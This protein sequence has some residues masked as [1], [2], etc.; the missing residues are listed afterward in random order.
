MAKS[1][2][3]K[4]GYRCASRASLNILS[5]SSQYYGLCIQ[6]SNEYARHWNIGIKR[7]NQ[8][9]RFIPTQRGRDKKLKLE[10]P[11]LRKKII[12]EVLPEFAERVR[13]KISP[14]MKSEERTIKWYEAA[15]A[16]ENLSE[17]I[18]D[19][20]KEAFTYYKELKLTAETLSTRN[21]KSGL[22]RDEFHLKVVRLWTDLWSH[23]AN[24]L[25][26]TSQ[27]LGT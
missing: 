13:K 26:E 8:E 14:R 16:D 12:E 5:D 6:A 19:D 7:I 10:I 4:Y 18:K 27:A 15:L 3:K 23:S 11:K 1:F 17:E 22:T 2:E 9:I 21:T 20:L 24:V 25:K